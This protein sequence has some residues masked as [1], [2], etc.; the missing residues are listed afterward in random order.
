MHLIFYK[1]D[2]IVLNFEFSLN[3]C[4][5]ESIKMNL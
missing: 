1:Q 4:I 3:Y 5:R 2:K